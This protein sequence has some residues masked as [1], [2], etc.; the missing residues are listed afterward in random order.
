MFFRQT[1]AE[2]PAKAGKKNRTE[3]KTLVERRR[4]PGLLAYV[5]EEPAGWVSIAPRRQ[6]G[7]IERSPILK[8]VD[9]AAAW[10]IV[11][12]FIGKRFRRQGLGRALV[13]AAVRYAVDKGAEAIEA[14]P[15][16]TARN[17]RELSSAELFVGTAAMFRKAGFKVVA[18]HK[19]A[20]PIM[21]YAAPR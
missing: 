16:D 11:C 10:S 19:D 9:D 6:F 13:D 5:D 3:L 21:R 7:R 8:P 2:F 18:R 20:R 17:P 12:L 4:V 14:Y 1:S 15:I